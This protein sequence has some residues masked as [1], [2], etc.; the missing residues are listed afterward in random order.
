MI[1]DLTVPFKR[2]TVILISIFF[3][4]FLFDLFMTE[5]LDTSIVEG[6]NSGFKVEYTVPNTGGG[7]SKCLPLTFS[8]LKRGQNVILKRSLFVDVCIVIPRTRTQG[9]IDENFHEY[10]FNR[11]PVVD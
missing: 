8:K 7:T 2:D 3:T 1:K 9:V 4:I 11:H 10:W 5:S 6:R